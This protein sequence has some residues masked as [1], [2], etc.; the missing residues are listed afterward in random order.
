MG[1]G[2]GGSQ[3]HGKEDRVTNSACMVIVGIS[4]MVTGMMAQDH[5]RIPSQP[6]LHGWKTPCMAETGRNLSSCAHVEDGKWCGL[7]RIDG[8]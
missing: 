8:S 1:W 6:H 5:P 2:L 3:T 4:C 7:G